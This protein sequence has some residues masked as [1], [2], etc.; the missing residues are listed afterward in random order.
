MSK[1][2]FNQ[3]KTLSPKKIR[4]IWELFLNLIFF[5]IF[6][7]NIFWRQYIITQW[8][9]NDANLKISKEQFSY[10]NRKILCYLPATGLFFVSLFKIFSFFLFSFYFLEPSKK[11]RWNFFHIFKNYTPK[12][13]IL[14]PM[15]NNVVR[16]SSAAAELPNFFFLKKDGTRKKPFLIFNFWFLT[17]FGSFLIFLEKYPIKSK[18][19][20]PTDKRIGGSSPASA[21][22]L[23]FLY[24]KNQETR[25]KHEKFLFFVSFL[26][27]FFFS[28]NTF[29][30]LRF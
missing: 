3:Y 11:S 26:E 30:N 2:I 24:T 21:A 19:L 13:E 16:S 14:G 4:K 17:L 6:Y 22:T 18:I 12:S 28:I 1:K 23:N 15:G 9:K 27:Y 20:T 8:R 29:S 5:F 7:L 25:K 10:E